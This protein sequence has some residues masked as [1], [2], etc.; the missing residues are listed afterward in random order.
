MLGFGWVF[1]RETSPPECGGVGSLLGTVLRHS[2]THP[3]PGTRMFMAKGKGNSEQVLE[4]KDSLKDRRFYVT[5][6]CAKGLRR[7]AFQARARRY[8]RTNTSGQQRDLS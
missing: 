2:L 4:D 6:L 3:S 5:D 8:Y 7:L 1:K